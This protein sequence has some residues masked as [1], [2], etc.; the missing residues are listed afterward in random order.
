MIVLVNISLL[1]LHPVCLHGVSATGYVAAKAA[2]LER[3][4]GQLSLQGLSFPGLGLESSWNAWGLA[5][6]GCP[7]VQ[8]GIGWCPAEPLWPTWA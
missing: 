7:R 8:F 4:W 6:P 3:F 1:A 2:T 5:E